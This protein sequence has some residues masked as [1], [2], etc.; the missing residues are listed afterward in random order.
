MKDKWKVYL[1]RCS[2]G[3]LYCGASNNVERRISV[4]NAGK[5]AKYV[6]SRTPAELVAVSKEMDK[7]N[8]LKLEYKVKQQ[9]RADKIEY[10][11]DH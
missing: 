11:K 5:G 9:K 3:T 10:L 2:D 4:H 7:K 8:A 6:R 1:L